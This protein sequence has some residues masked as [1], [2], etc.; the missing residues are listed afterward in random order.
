MK[1]NEYEAKIAELSRLAQRAKVNGDTTKYY[2]YKG[3]MQRLQ[4]E[5][6]GDFTELYGFKGANRNRFY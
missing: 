5:H 1:N 3:E 2:A 4:A 6:T